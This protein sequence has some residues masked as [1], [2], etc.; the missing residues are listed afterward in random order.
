MVVH[1][2]YSLSS[3]SLSL[4]LSLSPSLPLSP[5]SLF[6]P[7]LLPSPPPSLPTL[8]QLFSLLFPLL[9]PS[10]REVHPLGHTSSQLAHCSPPLLLYVVQPRGNVQHV[11][12]SCQRWPGVGH[13]VIEW[14]VHAGFFPCSA[15]LP[16]QPPASL[17]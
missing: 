3:L 4:T 9:L 5:F 13:L 2:C 15:I 14:S 6:L 8:G 10:P 11:P 17:D 16:H 1:A 7:P 12:S